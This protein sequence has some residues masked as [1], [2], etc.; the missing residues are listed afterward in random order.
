M[1]FSF[2]KLSI[3]L[4]SFYCVLL[5][6]LPKSFIWGWFDKSCWINWSNYIFH[7]GIGQIYFYGIDYNPLYMYVLNVYAHLM[8]STA[9]IAK[10]IHLLKSFT[11]IFEILC[12]FLSFKFASKFRKM[13]KSDYFFLFLFLLN[14]SYFYNTYFHGQVDSILG[15][16]IL[17]SLYLALT[18]KV[19]GSLIVFVFGL[20]FKLQ[21]IFSFPALG[22][23][24][25]AYYL[26][27]NSLKELAFHLSVVF[28]LQIVIIL[29]FLY[30]DS[31]H[32]IIDVINTANGRYPL[33]SMGAY[34]I[35]YLIFEKPTDI[36]DHLGKFG[37]SYNTYSKIVVIL[38]LGLFFLGS[39]KRFLFEIWK[40][41]RNKSIPRLSISPENSLLYTAGSYLICFTFFTQMHARY[42][43]PALICLGAYMVLTKRFW[44]FLFFSLV[45]FLNIEGT[46]KLIKGDTLDFKILFFQPYFVAI[47][48]LIVIAF[49]FYLLYFNR[50]FKAHE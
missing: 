31:V 23:I 42:S 26:K 45:Y 37:F 4:V 36:I 1:H 41:Y 28:S 46:G 20:N 43:F 40:S 21:M 14:I 8:G 49:L 35:W 5:F 15:F 29:P 50:S 34:N 27:K 18:N 7:Y 11:L 44:I 39:I 13:E 48:H 32:H 3:V 22:L 6:F 2:K 16:F 10:N 25:L 38:V 9:E 30:S 47:L 19:L 24:Y 17:L 33:V 12:I